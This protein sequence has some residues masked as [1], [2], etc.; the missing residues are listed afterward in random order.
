MKSKI[1]LIALLA[2]LTVAPC[3]T[4]QAQKKANSKKEIALQ[5]YS[6]REK[7]GSFNTATDNYSVDYTV[8]LKE[9]AQMGYTGVE[10]A[11]Y[12]DGKF[13]NR[14]P[15]VFKKDVEAA[16]LKVL[17]SHLSKPL[18]EEELA[19]GD[20]SESLKWWDKCIEAHKAAGM[21]YIV[22]PGIGV[23]KT[24]KDL[25]T[26]CDYFNEAGK[27]CR[28]NGLQ[29]GYHNHAH[30]FQKVEDKVVM[31]DYMIENTD[32][33]YV[34]IEM[35]VYW[36]VI[37][38]NSPVNYFRKYPGRFKVLH[39]KDHREVG[40][41]GMVGFDAIFNNAETAGVKHI[42]VELEGATSTIEEG[43]KTSIDYLLKAPFVKS[44]YN[45]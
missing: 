45:K 4:V 7:I 31:L 17:S 43:L 18:S 19:S 22:I 38:D 33:E 23:P 15:G 21:T 8:I 5:L 24:V 2:S 42:V 29:L 14:T 37:G 35:D 34:F 28:Q 36:V 3:V 41:S 6:V 30:E 12:S 1:Y 16:G 26:Y 27:K 44:S 11:G 32:P 13:Y 9:I 39:I 10:A 20:F 40:Q 25:K